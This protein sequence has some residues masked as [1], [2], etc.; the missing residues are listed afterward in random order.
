M[1]VSSDHIHLFFQCP[2]KYSVS[3]IAKKLKGRTSRT[4]RQ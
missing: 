3:L 2:P 4:L 1:S